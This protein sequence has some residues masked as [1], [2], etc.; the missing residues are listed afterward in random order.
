MV[1]KVSKKTTTK[2]IE[3]EKREQIE[4]GNRIKTIREKLEMTKI[5]LARR[6]GISGQFLGLIEEG[7][8]NLSYISI[9]KLMDLSGHSADYI[10]YGLD[11]SIIKDTKRLLKKYT[12]K[13]IVQAMNILKEIAIFIG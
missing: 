10:L 12:E 5:E 1:G 6:I 4:R 7:K 13:E 2:D 8:G 9:K 11:D 3:M